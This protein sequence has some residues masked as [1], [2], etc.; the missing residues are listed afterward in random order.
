[1]KKDSKKEG[2]D[3]KNKV[4]EGKKKVFWDKLILVCKGTH[5]IIFSLSI[6]SENGTRTWR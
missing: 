1:M 6:H 4:F 5:D 2:S 3:V